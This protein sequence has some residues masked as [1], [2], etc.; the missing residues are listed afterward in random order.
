M[1]CNQ[2]FLGRPKVGE[3]TTSGDRRGDTGGRGDDGRPVVLDWR[4]P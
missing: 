2:S 3:E 1:V 4:V